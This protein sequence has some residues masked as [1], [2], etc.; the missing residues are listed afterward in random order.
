MMTSFSLPGFP[1]PFSL[2]IL[3]ASC[4]EELCAIPTV[5]AMVAVIP[6]ADST[7]AKRDAKNLRVKFEFMDVLLSIG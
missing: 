6:R 5:G 7:E 1:S 4:V 3:F 2:R